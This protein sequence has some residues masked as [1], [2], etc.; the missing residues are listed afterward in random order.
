MRRTRVWL[1]LLVW[2]AV[3]FVA[4]AVGARATDPAW[5]LELERPAWAPPAWLFSP[6]WT[7]LYLLMGFAAWRVWRR[8]GFAGGALPLFLTQ[9]A[10]N[11]AWS[12]LF[13]GLRRPDL[14]FAEIVVL[15]AFILATLVAFWRRERLAGLLLAPYLLWVTY[16]AA[17]NLALWRM[18]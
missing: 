12:W 16:A 17:L 1:G 11:A 14:A 13:F 6:V 15:W 10:L 3:P 5:Y 4:A 2:I 18:N 7:A 9:L 8:S